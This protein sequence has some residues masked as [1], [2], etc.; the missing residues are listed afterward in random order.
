MGSRLLGVRS[1]LKKKKGKLKLR[2]RPLLKDQERVRIV[3][4]RG[5]KGSQAPPWGCESAR[6]G[7][8]SVEKI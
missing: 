8:Y 3:E 2:S 4:K 1:D 7:E 5:W 6:E